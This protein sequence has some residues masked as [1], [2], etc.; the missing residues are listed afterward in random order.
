MGSP[1]RLNDPDFLLSTGLRSTP[2][3]IPPTTTTRADNRIR[4]RTGTIVTENQAPM[5]APPSA[6]AMQQNAPAS[7][8]EGELT[9]VLTE[10]T[11]TIG[12]LGDFFDGLI[13]GAGSRRISAGDRGRGL[14]GPADDER[15]EE[16]GFEG[17]DGDD[18]EMNGGPR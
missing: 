11:S 8:V 12:T 13:V 2:T 17:G 4:D 1:T 18:E 7:V 5:P 14:D 16:E 9:R 15:Q 10:W 6:A 3:H